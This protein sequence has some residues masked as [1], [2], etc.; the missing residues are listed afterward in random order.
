[1]VQKVVRVATTNRRGNTEIHHMVEQV[2]EEVDSHNI[3][4]HVGTQTDFTPSTWFDNLP[5][6]N[7]L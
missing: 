2:G 1:M 4:N 5:G 3:E 6:P 7:W